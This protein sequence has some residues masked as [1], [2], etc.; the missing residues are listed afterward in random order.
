MTRVLI[1]GGR[2]RLG[3]ALA[4]K[5][6]GRHA[7]RTLARPDIDVADLAALET[8]L[9]LETYDVLVNG[10]GLTNVDRC[11]TDRVEAA[12]V[13]TEAPRRMGRAAAARGARFI[14]ISTDYVFDGEKSAP[15]V[16]SDPARPLSVYGETKL[17][18]EA[19][20][21]ESSASHLAVRVSW[22]F[23]PEKPSFVDAIVERA[24]T[25][26][27]VEAIAD[28][29]SCPTLADDV[30]DWLEPFLTDPLPGGLYHACNRGGCTWRDYGQQALDCAARAGAPLRTRIVEPLALEAMTAFVA[31][32]PRHTVMDTT[33]LS[34]V[35]GRA[36]RPWQDAVADYIAAK[37]SSL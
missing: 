37:F 24:L 10:T 2:G 12:T 27:R 6:G 33:K 25:Q 35:T 21:L 28:K 23:G 16:E 3:A 32:R 17:A 29:T 9:A 5:W 1:L 19:A 18:G 36:P 26:D 22:V 30:A 13:N 4:R 15:Y 8:L 11:E 31:R 7:V 34:T 14:H 20:A